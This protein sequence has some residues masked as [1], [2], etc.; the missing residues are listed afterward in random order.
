MNDPRPESILV[1]DD[2]PFNLQA[3][4]ALLENLGVHVVTAGSGKEALRKLL[5]EDFALIL[6]DVQMP[7]MDG[8]ETAE[9]IRQRER[10]RSTPIVF[11]TAWQE[12]PARIARAYSVGAVDFVV[13]PLDPVVLCSKVSVF[14]DLHRKTEALLRK[15]LELEAALD[16]AGRANEFKSRFLASISHEL[17]TPLGGI[18][19]YAELL[20]HEHAGPLTPQQREYLRHVLSSTEH[21]TRL[22]N[23]V[24]DLSKIEGGR[25]NMAPRWTP[26]RKL[27]DSAVGGLK[28][29]ATT[30]GVHVCIE[31]PRNFPS[32]YVDPLRIR[33]VLFNLLSNA[34][35]YS[36]PGST[37]TL[38]A[39]TEPR[40]AAIAVQDHGAGISSNQMARLFHEFEPSAPRDGGRPGPGLGLAIARHLVELHGGNIGVD[41]VVGQGSVFTVRLPLRRRERETPPL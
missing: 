36:P 10:S 30:A 21:L 4:S 7:D 15:N 6:L 5:D 37:T 31:I 38:R 20:E 41:T 3:L 2:E 27:A 24:L 39:Y 26:L 8:F 16:Q 22:V 34:I 32:L 28:A 23:D 1:V 14:L 9:L 13:K 17:R 11:Q 25:M 19:G 40:T 12:E 35:Q 33:P 29:A 18:L